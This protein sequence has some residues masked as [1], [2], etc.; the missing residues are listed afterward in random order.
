MS[1]GN[2]GKQTENSNE[3]YNDGANVAFFPLKIGS[4]LT[5]E[6]SQEAKTGQKS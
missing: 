6:E 5:E 2:D 3:S 4:E 1:F